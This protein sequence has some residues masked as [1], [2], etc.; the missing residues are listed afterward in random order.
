MRFGSSA[1]RLAYLYILGIWTG[2]KKNDGMKKYLQHSVHMKVNHVVF[3]NH[4]V[5]KRKFTLP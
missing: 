4:V 5:Q 1:V 3:L 2:D